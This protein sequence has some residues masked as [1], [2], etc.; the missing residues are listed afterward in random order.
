MGAHYSSLLQLMSASTVPTFRFR[1]I[2]VAFWSPAPY[3]IPRRSIYAG[4][5]VWGLGI[6]SLAKIMY[7]SVPTRR[8]SPGGQFPQMSLCLFG[9]AP[10]VQ[11]VSVVW[12]KAYESHKLE[13]E[14]SENFSCL[15]SSL[16]E[17]FD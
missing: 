11:S 6:L 16:A 8:D 5:G 17:A 4:V 3:P 15:C 13:S 1:S 2:L 7:A 14:Y 10:Q 12:A 9:A